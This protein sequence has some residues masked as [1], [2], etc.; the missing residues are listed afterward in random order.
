MWLDK[1][2]IDELCHTHDR[3]DS[4]YI[5][6]GG[7]ALHVDSW[8]Q[9]GPDVHWFNNG[10]SRCS[11]NCGWRNFE[12]TCVKHILRDCPDLK[13]VDEKLVDDVA[14]DLDKYEIIAFR[15][16]RHYFGG[17]HFMRCERN[18]DWTEKCGHYSCISRHNY[19]NIHEAWGKDFDGREY[20][21]IRERMGS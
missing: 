3:E 9:I 5:N 17:Y 20:F 19:E 18:G 4:Y 21:F 2:T 8:Y 14:I 10:L 16:D 7:H 6:C 1:K 11:K 15:I 12:R 13:L